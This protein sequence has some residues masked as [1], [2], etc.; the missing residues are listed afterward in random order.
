MGSYSMW[1]SVTD[2]LHFAD[3][4]KAHPRC[5]WIR[6]PLFLGMKPFTPHFVY[7]RISWW[8]SGLWIMLLFHLCTCVCVCVCVHM[9]LILLGIYQGVEFLS[10]MM[11]LCCTFWGTAKLFLKQLHQFRF[12]PAIYEGSNFFASLLTLLIVCFAQW[13]W[14][15]TSLWFW[16]T[17]P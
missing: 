12:P 10:Y 13:M 2:F 7:P 3:V 9:V 4:F 1:A 16:V 11:I 15:G 5:C 14:S 6:I 8:T 17:F